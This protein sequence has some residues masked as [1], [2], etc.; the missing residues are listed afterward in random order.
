MRELTHNEVHDVSGGLSIDY[1]M[2]D[3]DA[4]NLQINGPGGI[5]IDGGLGID[6]SSSI[7]NINSGGLVMGGDRMLKRDS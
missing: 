6:L 4:I 2:L 7:G 5:Q 3:L 1:S